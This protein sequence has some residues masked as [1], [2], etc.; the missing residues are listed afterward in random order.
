MTTELAVSV[1]P[2]RLEVCE[3]SIAA[4][5]RSSGSRSACCAAPL[6]V[7]PEGGNEGTTRYYVCTHCGRPA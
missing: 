4:A 5:D 6:R 1:V 2:S 3:A 7:A